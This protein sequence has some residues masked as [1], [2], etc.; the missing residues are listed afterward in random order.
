VQSVQGLD[1]RPHED[2]GEVTR[3]CQAVE[4]FGGGGTLLQQGSP[5]VVVVLPVLRIQI[6][7]PPQSLQMWLGIDPGSMSRSP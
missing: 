2:G 3:S 1:A 4:G 7:G 6:D 5:Q